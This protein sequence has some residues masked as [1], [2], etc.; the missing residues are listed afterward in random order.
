MKYMNSKDLITCSLVCKSWNNLAARE[1]IWKH[2]LFCDF[3]ISIQNFKVPIK[4]H[5]NNQNVGKLSE[6]SY[7]IPSKVAYK[8][9]AMTFLK[10]AYG[11][12]ETI[13]SIPTT[14]PSSFLNLHI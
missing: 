10:I 12:T 7:S 2:L 14:M 3:K 4:D 6:N 1:D 13:G 5:T 11:R 8:L 9:M